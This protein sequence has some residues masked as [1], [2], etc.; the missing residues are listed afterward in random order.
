MISAAI[1]FHFVLWWESQ[2]CGHMSNDRL[3]WVPLPVC[4][5]TT[6]IHAKIFC[7][8]RE[9]CNVLLTHVEWF[10]LSHFTSGNILQEKLINKYI[11]STSEVMNL[12]VVL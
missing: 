12:Y 1:I 11:F 5:H 6:I 2:S 10:S 4:K 8:N 3:G 7:N 9:E